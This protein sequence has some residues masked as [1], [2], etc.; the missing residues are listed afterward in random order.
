MCMYVHVLDIFSLNET[1]NAFF[2]SNL[3]NQCI[4]FSSVE[5][6]KPFRGESYV[7][8]CTVT[9]VSSVIGSHFMNF[10]LMLIHVMP[11]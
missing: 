11:C 1:N 9:V 5:L 4:K 6:K 3:F 10:Y 7:S 2:I 8:D